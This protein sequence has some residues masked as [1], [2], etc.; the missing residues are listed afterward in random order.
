MFVNA[1]IIHND[2]GVGGGIWLHIVKKSLNKMSETFD[3]IGAFNDFTV[4]NT[5][6]REGWED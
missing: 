6:Q 5:I 1:T 2:N 3:T 4:N